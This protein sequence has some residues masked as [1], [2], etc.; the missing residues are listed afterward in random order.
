M[1]S[2]HNLQKLMTA[3]GKFVV[4]QKG[5]WGHEEWEALLTKSERYGVTADQDTIACMG[6]LLESAKELYN[7]IPAETPKKTKKK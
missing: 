3:L 7:R 4:E 2:T 1:G 5:V 6:S